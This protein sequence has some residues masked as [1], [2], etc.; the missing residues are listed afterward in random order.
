MINI[1]EGSAPYTHIN[2]YTCSKDNQEKLVDLVIEATENVLKKQPG[3]I[4]SAIHKSIDG[5]KVFSYTQWKSD[6][7]IQSMAKHK[8]IQP[9]FTRGQEL[10]EHEGRRVQVISVIEA[11][12]KKSA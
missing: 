12:H 9:F 7:D 6:A 10:A 5:N 4:A 8:E 11:E 1:A 2:E 3:F